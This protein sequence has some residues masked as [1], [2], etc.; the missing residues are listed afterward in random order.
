MIVSKTGSTST[1]ATTTSSNKRLSGL[2]SGLDTDSL[3]KQLSAGTQNKIDKQAQSK[4]IAQWQ[5]SSYREVIKALTEFQTKYFSTATS[6]S[7]ILNPGFFTST[8]IKNSSPF[9]NVTGN[10]N[11]AKN[12]VVTKISQLA[13]QA[14]FT[15]MHKA[16]NEAITTGALSTSWSP[17]NIAGSTMTINYGG[18]DYKLTLDSSVVFNSGD[19]VSKITDA[20]NDAIAKTDGLAGKVQFSV[21][22]NK[23]TLTADSKISITDGTESLLSGLNLNKGDSGNTISSPVEAN[24]DCFFKNTL[25]AGS[26]LDIK[27]GTTSYTLTIPKDTQIS[28]D[29]AT[30]AKSLQAI[31]S[32]AI[33]SNTDASGKLSDLHDKL[34]V[35]VDNTGAVTFKTKDGVSDALSITGG[36]QNLLQ[37]LGLKQ[38]DGTISNSGTVDRSK[39]VSSYL[40]DTLAGSTLTFSLDGVK[41]YITLDASDLNSAD[42]DYST[43][44]KLQAY[45]QKKLTAEFGTAKDASGAIVSKVNVSINSGK[46]SFETYKDTTQN[47]VAVGTSVLS[48]DTCDKSGVLGTNGAL[49]VYAGE[50]NRINTNKTLED[51]QSN[52]STPLQAS[53]DGTYGIIINDQKFTFKKTDTIDTVL[54]TINNDQHANVNITYSSVNDSFSVAAKNGGSASRVDIKNIDGKCNL[55]DTLFGTVPTKDTNGNYIE[56]S[57]AYSLTKGQDAKMTVSLDGNAN[58]AIE[59]T[60]SENK[61]TLDGVNFELLSKTDDTV[62]ADKPIK[63]TADSQTDKLYDKIKSFVDDYNSIITLCTTKIN[64]RQSASDKYLP[65]T[66]DQK[67][68]M[69]ET[70]ITEYEKKAKVGILNSDP[71]LSNLCLNLRKAMTDQVDSVKGALFEIGIATKANDY[72]GNGQITVDETK[73]KNALTNDPD[74]VAALFT[75]SDGVAYKM[76]SV[77]NDNIKTTGGSGLLVAKAGLDNSTTYD[78]STLTQKISDYTKTIKDLQTRL[79]DEQDRYYSKFTKLEQYISQ[80]NAQSGIFTNFGTSS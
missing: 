50:T 19:S 11:A 44:E 68:Q 25:T 1:S 26:T 2:V 53:A 66:D 46:L 5:Q 16:S 21:D 63:F 58:N 35:T 41:K 29:P 51:I 54:K 18:K 43:P 14:S 37:G 28:S 74:K 77:I 17:N 9:L 78:N 75:D 72:S 39:L 23:V 32:E 71:L 65:L 67:A 52:L 69:T 59:I 31:L 7:S 8:A 30:A 27:I 22:S 4:Q 20:L 56:N 6:S 57:S 73:L 10:A 60:R 80:M 38:T 42:N 13:Q 47:G 24:T 15:S 55:A 45:L 33:R 62:S 76:Q 3:V 61:F 40:G 48:L 49:K 79:K 64:E 36:S 12:M 34:D 70:Q